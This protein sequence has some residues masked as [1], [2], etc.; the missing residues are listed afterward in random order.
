[1]D[2]LETFFGKVFVFGICAIWVGTVIFGFFYF[3]GILF[4]IMAEVGPFMGLFV[5]FF[6]IF[7]I[8]PVILT[9]IA[10]FKT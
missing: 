1:M 5:L 9:L 2:E 4:G 6:G 7:F 10:M 8:S 3:F